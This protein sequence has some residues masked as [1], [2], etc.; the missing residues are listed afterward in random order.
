MCKEIYKF[1][2][3]ALALISTEIIKVQMY[4]TSTYNNVSKGIYVPYINR[5]NEGTDVPYINI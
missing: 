3:G 4:H 1:V 2:D 5:N